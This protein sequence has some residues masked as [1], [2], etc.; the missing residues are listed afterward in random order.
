MTSALAKQY[1][2]SSLPGEYISQNRISRGQSGIRVYAGFSEE[3]NNE[4]SIKVSYQLNNPFD[5][6][7]IGTVDITSSVQVQRGWGRHQ[8]KILRIQTAVKSGCILRRREL[9]ITR[10]VSV[11]T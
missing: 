9:F 11:H 6:F 4:I 8:E 3:L 2:L 1:L 10:A 7:G 5:V